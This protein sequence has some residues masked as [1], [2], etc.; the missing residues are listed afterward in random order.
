MKTAVDRIVEKVEIHLGDVIEDPES[1]QAFVECWTLCIDAT[2]DFGFCGE[3]AVSLAE[4]A[5]A[6][7]GYPRRK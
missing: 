3:H 4:R 5:C 1:P 2:H 6:K 7:L